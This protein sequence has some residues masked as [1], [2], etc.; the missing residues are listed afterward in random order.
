MTGLNV[1]AAIGTVVA[2][3]GFNISTFEPMW[4]RAVIC[5]SVGVLT[6]Y[7]ISVISAFLKKSKAEN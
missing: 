5:M 4:L 1:P 3:S 2:V 7:L 6:S